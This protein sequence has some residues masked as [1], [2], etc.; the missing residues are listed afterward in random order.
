MVF[1]TLKAMARGGMND[2]LAGGFHRY[3]VDERWFV[4][5]FEK[6]LYDQALLSISYLEAYQATRDEFHARVA[7]S[8]LDYVLGEMTHPDGGFYSAEDADSVIDPA[9]PEV[10]GE[11]AFYIWERSEIAK[12]LG[13]P[14]AGR[15]CD[16][17]AFLERQREV[18]PH[19]EFGGR[20]ILFVNGA[21]EDADALA[22]ARRKL[23]DARA[24]RIRPHRD[25]K[26]LTS[27][28]ALMISGF[29]RAAQVLDEPR[30]AAAALKAV[31]FVLAN[32]Y[33]ADQGTLL[34]RYREGEAAIPGFLDDYAFL[35]QALLDLYETDFDPRWLRLALAL[36]ENPGI[37]RRRSNGAFSA[38][39]RLAICFRMKDDHDGAELSGYP[40][41]APNLLAWPRSP[42]AK[43]CGGR[44]RIFEAASRLTGAPAA[45]PQMLV[46]VLR[47]SAPPRQVVIAGESHGAD[48]QALL[49]EV[50][51]RFLPDTLVLVV[52][53]SARSALA[54]W[55]PALASMHPTEGRPASSARASPAG[56]P[57]PSLPPGSVA[58]IASPI[59]SQEI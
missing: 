10:K 49:A 57:S 54:D 44:P 59:P 35:A 22:Q 6:M 52:N 14:E 27:W 23:L 47:A 11:G 12:I 21:D 31:E 46:A 19:G 7:R 20:N 17:T 18:D 32:L 5:H 16:I 15:F 48:T 2:Q 24:L 36:T 40:I 9:R 28:N 45:V 1:S 43:I 50:R 4:P 34:R 53:G 3:S 58:K 26:I 42:A 13:E 37:V 41:A 55:N 8:T 30:Y 25:D 38:P 29:A 33:D 56:S 51:L 39:P